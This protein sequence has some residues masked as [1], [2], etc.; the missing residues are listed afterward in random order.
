[1]AVNSRHGTKFKAARMGH[2]DYETA[3]NSHF[4]MIYWL[5]LLKKLAYKHALTFNGNTA[6][7]IGIQIL[8]VLN[9]TSLPYTFY[10]VSNKYDFI[11]IS[12]TGL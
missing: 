3:L 4:P 7:D 12:N 8:F 9:Q 2:F 10:V 5:V 11:Y 1:M 6:I